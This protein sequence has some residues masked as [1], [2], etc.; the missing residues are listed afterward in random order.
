MLETSAFKVFHGGNLALMLDS[1][2]IISC[3]LHHG[4]PK[5]IWMM[6]EILLSSLL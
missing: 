5:F 1:N 4:E 6:S 3:M 2:N